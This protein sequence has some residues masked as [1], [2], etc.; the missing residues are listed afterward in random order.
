MTMAADTP[1]TEGAASD[2]H[3]DPAAEHPRAIAS[4]RRAKSW[5]AIAG[6][7][8]TAYLGQKA[9]VPFVDLVIRSILIGAATSLAVWGTAQAIW[10]QIVFAELAAARKEALETQKAIL[11]ELEDPS[12]I[13]GPSA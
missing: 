6:F 2:T 12:R 7:A 5:G 8:I 9:G 10:K 13:D 4:I 11:E 1:T 3:A